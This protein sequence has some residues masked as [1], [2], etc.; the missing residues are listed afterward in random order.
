MRQTDLVN[1]LAGLL[2]QHGAENVVQGLA[3]ACA[4]QSVSLRARGERPE[5]EDWRTLAEMLQAL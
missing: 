2:A 4:A 5:A 3:A 1:S